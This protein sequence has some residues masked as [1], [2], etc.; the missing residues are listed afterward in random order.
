MTPPGGEIVVCARPTDQ[1]LARLPTPPVSSPDAPM[2]FRL[3]GGGTGNVHAVQ[4]TLPGA[5]GSGAVVTLRIP[6][7]P[8]RRAADPAR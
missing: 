6:F 4:S 7:G 8:G 5:T 3:P 2:T 1:R